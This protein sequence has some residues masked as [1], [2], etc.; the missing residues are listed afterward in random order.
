MTDNQSLKIEKLEAEINHLKHKLRKYESESF[1]NTVKAPTE[2]SNAFKNAELGVGNYFKEV[3]IQPENATIEIGGERYVLL[4]AASL[5]ANFLHKVQSLYADKGE[6]QA[7]QI[8][9]N[10][11]FDI[12]HV[13]GIEDAKKIHQ[14]L[15]LKDPISKLSAGPVH[16]AHTGWANVE[17][18]P[19]SNPTPD[20]NFF[21]KYNHPSSFEADTWISNNVKTKETVCVMNTG[22]SSGWC[23]ESFGIPLTAVEVSCRARGDENCTFIMAHPSKIE[24]YLEHEKSYTKNLNL[25][26]PV[27]F[28]RKKQE[29]VIQQSLKEKELLLKEIHHRVKNNLQIISSL[30]NLQSSLNQEIDS[31]L[32]LE[33]QN[34]IKTLALVHEML[35]NSTD[36][37]SIPFSKYLSELIDLLHQSYYTPQQKIALEF[38]ST[39]GDLNID[40]DTM[41]PV[42]LIVNEIVSNAFKH[43]F[44]DKSQGKISLTIKQENNRIYIEIHNNGHPIPKSFDLL[45][46]QSLGVEVILTLI[47][48]IKGI[49]SIEKMPV[50]F[51]FDFPFSK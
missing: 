33:T 36:I 43:G 21:L 1:Y 37:R 8:G 39:L 28:K 22:Y 2:F 23:E 16:F 15:D 20:K 12:A 32:F 42:G 14:K 29:E 41:I 30:I 17:I 6:E 50:R 34:R 3:L 46:S 48:Q 51:K 38:N 44:K 11:L 49:I 26:I 27:F 19:E 7:F 4:R 40:I 31:N 25:E 24:S 10:F 13:L 18:L 47:D 35:Y 5:S 9:R 45:N